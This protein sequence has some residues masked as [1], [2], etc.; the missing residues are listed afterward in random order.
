MALA[1]VVDAMNPI[2]KAAENHFAGGGLKNASDGNVD[3]ARDHLL[4]VVDHH[5]GAGVQISDALVVL[6]AFF[7]NKDAHSFTGEYNRL[8]RIGQLI[9][10]QDVDAVQLRHFIQIEIVG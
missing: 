6:F 3:G 4:G 7:Q 2:V 8:Q 5:H 1:L 10:V 9:D